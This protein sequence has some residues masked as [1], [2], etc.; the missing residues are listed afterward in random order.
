MESDKTEMDILAPPKGTLY[1]RPTSAIQLL[2]VLAASNCVF[3]FLVLSELV[4]FLYY[5]HWTK[6]YA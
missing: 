1:L 6:L 3:L 4:T 5:V 2:F